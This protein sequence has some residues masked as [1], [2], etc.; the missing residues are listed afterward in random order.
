MKKFIIL[1]ALILS[2]CATSYQPNGFI[3]NGGF[4]D[5]QLA[6]NYYRVT[7]KGNEKTSKERAK[8]FALLRASELMKQNGCQSFKVV[9]E[10]DEVRTG[11]IFLPQ[12]HTTNINTTQFGNYST[13]TATTTSYGGGVAKLHFP[14][15]IIE[16]LCVTD[17]PDI[18]KNIYDTNFL[19]KS[20]KDKYKI[21]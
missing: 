6:P 12:T 3:G 13:G 8:D 9:K 5:T 17:L 14:K 19:N 7:F 2:G 18:S 10:N 4:D 1:A 21:K 15:A 11:D 16:V 20:L